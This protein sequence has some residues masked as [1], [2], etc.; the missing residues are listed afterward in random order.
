MKLC[1][2]RGRD[3]VLKGE[4]P[5]VEVDDQNVD[6]APFGVYRIG[7]NLHQVISPRFT[8]KNFYKNLVSSQ[9]IVSSPDIFFS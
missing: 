3:S 8:D 5:Q 9:N 4:E 2:W 1:L 7:V 6:D